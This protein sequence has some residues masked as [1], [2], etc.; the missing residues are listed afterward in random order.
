ME[1][2]QVD[3]IERTIPKDK[4][5]VVKF[6]N[7]FQTTS[8]G[9][10]SR[11]NKEF[12]VDG[13]IPWI[14]SGELGDGPISQAEEHITEEAVK[15]S[16]A[17]VFPPGTL[18]LALYGATIGKVSRLKIYAATN[19]AICGIFES[20]KVDS[21]FCFWY[22]KYQRP[23]LM[24]QGIG[25]AQPN[26]SQSIVRQLEFPLPPLPEQRAIVAKLERLFAELDR[27]VAELEA[28]REK[29][30]V[31]RQ[32]VLK[33]AFA[34]RLTEGWR[35]TNSIVSGNDYLSEIERARQNYFTTQLAIWRSKK[36]G[37][38]KPKSIKSKPVSKSERE[39]L[40]I[41]NVW[42]AVYPQDVASP[43]D[44]SIGIGPFGS[45]LKVEDYTESGVPL[46]FVRNI[47]RADY[48][49]RQKFVTEEKYQD[50]IPH[51]VKPL[52]ILVTKMGDPPGDTDIYPADAPMAILT[53][54]CLKFRVWEEFADRKFFRYAIE[55]VYIKQQL[56]LIT[57]G[58]AQKKISAGRFK[59]LV[60]PLPTLAEQNQIVQEIETRFS[61]ADK[62][63]QEIAESLERARG[64]RQGVLK[65]AFAG[66]LI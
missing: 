4:W 6:G 20:P 33:E 15:K 63:E 21:D 12:Y 11:R 57:Q 26:I 46:I 60:F 2:G 34:G 64:L 28:A 48:S 52:D 10:P 5:E 25:G 40:D 38:K 7:V 1:E 61:V 47:T 30:G 31:Y 23:K 42:T 54:D 58:V 59:T 43:E 14:K 56:G 9:T 51:S 8:G 62:L 16:S 29:L 19:Q 32:S 18:L 27:S 37:S 36:D 13:T 44:Y 17:K 49:L 35:E 66:E 39:I 50:L 22:L 55:S 45:N 41:P 65:R 3:V 53:S 24:S